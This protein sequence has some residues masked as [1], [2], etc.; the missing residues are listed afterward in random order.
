MCLLALSKTGGSWLPTILLPFQYFDTNPISLKTH[1]YSD[2]RTQFLKEH[3]LVHVFLFP[4]LLVKE[5]WNYNS[6]NTNSFKSYIYQYTSWTRFQIHNTFW[7]DFVQQFPTQCPCLLY[8]L[9]TSFLGNSKFSC[10]QSWL[11][12]RSGAVN[13]IADHIPI[14][15]ECLLVALHMYTFQT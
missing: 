10:G 15:W 2:K 1:C 11:Y 9:S 3:I 4:C 14:T 6:I 13:T 12:W 8:L 5:T 7:N